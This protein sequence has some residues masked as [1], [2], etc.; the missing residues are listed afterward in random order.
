MK[1]V[2]RVKYNAVLIWHQKIKSLLGQMSIYNTGQVQ[3]GLTTV[4]NVL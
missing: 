3:L 1:G 4:A 2:L